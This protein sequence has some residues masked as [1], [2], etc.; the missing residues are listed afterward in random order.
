MTIYRY[1]LK[2]PTFFVDVEN[3]V[4]YTMKELR[5]L[6]KVVNIIVPFK[7]WELEAFLI[8][9]KGQKNHKTLK[10]GLPVWPEDGSSK[11]YIC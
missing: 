7:K 1:S 5:L 4:S 8:S 3:M 2:V 9:E 11:V 6:K 10:K